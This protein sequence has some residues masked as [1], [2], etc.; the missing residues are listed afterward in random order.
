MA[1]EIRRLLDSNHQY[2]G[3][4]HNRKKAEQVKY[5]VGVRQSCGID[6]EQLE[7]GDD[8]G[9]VLP[10]I[11]VKE[12]LVPVRAR[13]RCRE[14]DAEVA[15]Q[16]DEVSAPAGCDGGCAEGILEYQIPANDPGEDLTQ[17]RVAVGV[18]RTGDRNRRSFAI[19][20]TSFILHLH[21]LRTK[22]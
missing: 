7:L 9:G 14:F 17:R 4:K 20:A 18:S 5:S 6:S 16:A 2:Q 21:K 19:S 15:E 10:M 22:S 3:A 8:L 13:C 12:E 1:V 11:V